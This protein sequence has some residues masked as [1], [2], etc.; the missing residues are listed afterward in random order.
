MGTYR[1]YYSAAIVVENNSGGRWPTA[2]EV[3]FAPYQKLT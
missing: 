1:Q 3:P 2:L